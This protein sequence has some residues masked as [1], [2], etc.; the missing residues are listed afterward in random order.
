MLLNDVLASFGDAFGFVAVKAGRLDFFF[1]F[2]KPGISEILRR[3]VFL[4]KLRRHH[5]DALVSALRGK[6]RGD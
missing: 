3:S 4:E 1:E 5:V 6:D 2:G